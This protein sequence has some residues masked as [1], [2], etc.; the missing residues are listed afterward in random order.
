MRGYVV[1]AMVVL[2]LGSSACRR[3]AD[4]DADSSAAREPDPAGRAGPTGYVGVGIYT[5]S[6]AWQRLVEASAQPNAALARKVDDQVVIVVQNSRNGDIRACG[7]MTGYCVGMNPWARPPSQLTPVSL[8]DHQPTEEEQAAA[9]KQTDEAE[10]KK[11]KQILAAVNRAAA[12][13]R[14]HRG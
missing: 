7:D 1:A 14:H 10:A 3:K 6:L 8:T 2:V 12:R 5:P 9:Q 4:A 11:Q 13:R